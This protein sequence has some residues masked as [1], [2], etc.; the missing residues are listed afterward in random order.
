MAC[1]AARVVAVVSAS[2]VVGDQPGVGRGLELAAAQKRLRWKA[3]RQH[4]WRMLPWKRSTT[5][6]WLGE[7][8]GMRT[9]PV[10]ASRPRPASQTSTENPP[11]SKGR[12][13]AEG[14]QRPSCFS[15]SRI[16]GLP[17][18]APATALAR[19]VRAVGAKD[20]QTASLQ[21][22]PEHLATSG[23]VPLGTSDTRLNGASAPSGNLCAH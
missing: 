12:R 1:A 17:S 22:L 2:V 15:A 18:I 8:A 4:S 13:L 11:V 5:A 6:L 7:R 3:G 16:S 21:P 10:A 19:F 23:G 9:S 14:P 20:R